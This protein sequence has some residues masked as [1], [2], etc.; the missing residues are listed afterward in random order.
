MAKLWID[1]NSLCPGSVQQTD[2]RGANK[3]TMVCQLIV[4]TRGGS[5]WWLLLVVQKT[6]EP[7]MA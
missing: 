7:V 6:T 3:D 4:H 5:C 1:M 2:R